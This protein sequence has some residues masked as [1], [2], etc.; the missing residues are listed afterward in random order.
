VIVVMMS[1]EERSD[2][3]DV[4]PGF[5]ETARDPVARIDDIQCAIDDEKI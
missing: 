4:D 1:D 2:V 3:T 5:C